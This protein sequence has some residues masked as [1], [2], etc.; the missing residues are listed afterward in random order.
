LRDPKIWRGSTVRPRDRYRT[1]LKTTPAATIRKTTAAMA[2][3]SE[4]TAAIDWV[5]G[6]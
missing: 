1:T 6:E 5:C 2:S 3:T 4:N